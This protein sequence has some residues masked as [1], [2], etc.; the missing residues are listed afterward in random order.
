MKKREATSSIFGQAVCRQFCFYAAF[1]ANVRGKI[2]AVLPLRCDA[3]GVLCA[4][5]IGRR[6]LEQFLAEATVQ[7][8]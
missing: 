2:H 7:S 6:R 8:S 4:E 1:H 3:D 5:G